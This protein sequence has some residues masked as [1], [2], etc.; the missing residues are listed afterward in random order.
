MAKEVL[1]KD[2]SDLIRAMTGFV[3][4]SMDRTKHYMFAAV[5]LNRN[6]EHRSDENKCL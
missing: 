3:L 4:S 6:I 2:L 1:H 5:S